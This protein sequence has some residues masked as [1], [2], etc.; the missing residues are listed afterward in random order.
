MT[1]TPYLLLAFRLPL[2]FWI[3]LWKIVL[4]AALA[5]FS[6]MAVWVTIG[7]FFDVKRLFQRIDESHQEDADSA[8]PP[9]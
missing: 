3:I 5:L 8:E 1:H 9:S 4:V 7:G 2:E 6:G